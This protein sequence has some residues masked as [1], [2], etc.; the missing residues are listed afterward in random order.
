[1]TTASGVRKHSSH[2]PPKT[3]LVRGNQKLGPGIF[4]WSLPAGETCPGQTPACA[5]HCYAKSGHYI[6]QNVKEVHHRNLDLTKDDK[7]VGWMG[8]ELRRTMPRVVRI[9]VSGDFYSPE[10]TAKWGRIAKAYSE[11]TFFA[12]TRSW[13][14]PQIRVELNKLA[15]LPNVR[16]WFSVD[17]DTGIPKRMPRRVK[18]AWMQTAADDLPPRSDLVFRVRSL[19]KTVTKRIGL[20]LVCPVENGATA[21][22]VTCGTCRI[23]WSEPQ[24]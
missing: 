15:K 8:R 18:L 13:R 14:V 1:M 21:H 6:H 12:F 20:T 3:L 5:S 7:F 2:D 9:H 10:Y 16:L 11:T 23:C 17:C 22:R 24:S 19:R 4:S